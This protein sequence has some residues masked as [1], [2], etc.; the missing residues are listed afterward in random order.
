M[1]TKS[2]P[3]VCQHT[4]ELVRT[5]LLIC[6][7]IPLGCEENGLTVDD[8]GGGGITIEGGEVHANEVYAGDVT[9]GNVQAGVIGCQKPRI[10][11]EQRI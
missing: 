3:S 9:A 10:V 4:Y 6:L 7:V 1:R 5:L 11:G 8:E 2:G